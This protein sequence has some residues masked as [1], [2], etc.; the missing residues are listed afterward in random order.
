[1]KIVESCMPSLSS[2]KRS[3]ASVTFLYV[4]V[5]FFLLFLFLLLEKSYIVDRNLSFTIFRFSKILFLSKRRFHS[6]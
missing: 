1:M 3:R 4:V 2:L 5:F 6:I